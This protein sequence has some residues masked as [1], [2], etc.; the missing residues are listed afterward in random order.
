MVRDCKRRRYQRVYPI[1]R[2]R[3]GLTMRVNIPLLST[4]ADIADKLE[5]VRAAYNYIDSQNILALAS[6]V[7]AGTEGAKVQIHPIVA[8]KKHLVGMIVAKD[9][10]TVVGDAVLRFYRGDAGSEVFYTTLSIPFGD[11]T[12]HSLYL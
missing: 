3:D 1:G 8:E 6:G 11:L 9:D 7:G 2:D 12:A 4:V 10:A 5:Q